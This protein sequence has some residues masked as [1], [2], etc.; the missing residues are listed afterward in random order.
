VRAR[1]GFVIRERCS[2]TREEVAGRTHPSPCFSEKCDSKGVK[3]WGSA[4]NINPKE[5]AAMLKDRAED[6]NIKHVSI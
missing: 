3:W 5:L 6:E 2:M 4:K 1:S